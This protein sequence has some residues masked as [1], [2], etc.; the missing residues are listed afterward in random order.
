MS[1]TERE[2]PAGFVPLSELRKPPAL[3]GKELLDAVRGRLDSFTAGLSESEQAM[4]VALLSQGTQ[5]PDLAALAAETPAAVL[6]PQ[7]AELFHQLLAAP[8]PEGSG[9]QLRPALAVIMKAT[10][11]C[12]L[13]CTYCRS[14]AEG[15]D[16]KMTFEVLA[17]SIHGA[18]SAPGVTSVEFVWHGGETT[19]RPVSFY[20]KALWLQQRFRRPGQ[21]V[22]NTVQ[23]NGTNLTAEWLDFLKRYRFSVGVSLD[24]PPEVH[25]RRRLDT[26][27]RPTSHRVQQGLRRL[28]EHGIRHGVLMVVDDDVIALG[29]RRLLDYFLELGVRHVSLLNVVPE[30]EPER[31]MP[32]DYVALARFVTFLRELF[33]AWWPEAADRIVFR[34]ISD[35]A[36]RL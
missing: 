14:W 21:K 18:L 22:A 34:E 31:A 9:G 29:A 7:E 27:G 5:N 1:Q 8:A 4:L 16:Q 13:R 33:H 19:L 35:L 23:T 25:D 2:K 36:D 26:R 6:G 15:P 11:I 20:R 28:Q 3:G 17:R 32:G 30:G 10:K 12:N 24:G